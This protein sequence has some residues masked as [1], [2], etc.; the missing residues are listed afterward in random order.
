M[1][2]D[3]NVQQSQ[4]DGTRRRPHIEVKFDSEVH[5]NHATSSKPSRGDEE[6]ELKDC[7]KKSPSKSRTLTLKIWTR[8]TSHFQ[9]V[10]PNNT[11]SKWK[12][13]IRC[14]LAAWIG[15]IIFVVPASEKAMGQV[16]I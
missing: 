1:A 16:I 5:D 2:Q 15:A 10:F 6:I 12:P 9:W 11:W 13:V 4:L 14:A 8:L 7:E 3:G